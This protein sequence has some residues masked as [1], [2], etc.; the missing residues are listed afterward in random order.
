[1]RVAEGTEHRRA[2]H[3]QYDLLRESIAAVA[4]IE[5]VGQS[6]VRLAV[7]RQL[8]VEQIDRYFVS[9]D[10]AHAELPGANDD[11]AAFD[12]HRGA[13]VRRLEDVLG[14]PDHRALGLPAG[15]VDVLLEV[16]LSVQQRNA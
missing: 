11:R 3:A 2:P 6:A 4:A 16:S 1:A 8:R 5:R 13:D 14:T 9:R 12:R 10:S 7:L 15:A